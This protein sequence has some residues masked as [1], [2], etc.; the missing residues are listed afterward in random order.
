MVPAD[1]DELARLGVD[2]K[3]KIVNR[4]LWRKLAGDQTKSCC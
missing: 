3:G 4:A 1:Y 2:V